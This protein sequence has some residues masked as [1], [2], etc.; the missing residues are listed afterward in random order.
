MEKRII[1]LV[2]AILVAIAGS[3][4]AQ[5]IWLGP[6]VPF[7]TAL[8]QNTSPYFCSLVASGKLSGELAPGQTAYLGPGGKKKWWK[9]VVSFRSGFGSYAGSSNVVIPVVALCF[10]NATNEYYVGEADTILNIPGGGY[11][12]T[13]TWIIRQG[14]IHCVDTVP[15]RNPQPGVA[16]GFEEKNLKIEFPTFWMEGMNGIQIVNNSDL[17]FLIRT[18][19]KPGDTAQIRPGEMYYLAM[20]GQ[21]AISVKIDAINPLAQN[22]IGAWNMDFYGQTYGYQGQ[23]IVL[24]RGSFH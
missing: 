12:S 4:S 16:T 24:N 7:Q 13:T 2:A 10:T 1:F 21:R 3:A 15:C 17:I 20:W 8:I 6:G 23:N 19:R 14:D 5:S 11:S 18:T 22:L 9:N